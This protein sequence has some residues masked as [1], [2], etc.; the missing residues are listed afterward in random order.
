MF[1][2]FRIIIVVVC[3]MILYDHFLTE[4]DVPS[5]DVKILKNDVRVVRKGSNNSLVFAI[6]AQMYNLSP[7]I[8]EDVV[9]YFTFYDCPRVD[10]SKVDCRT[11]MT[12]DFKYGIMIKP[13][14]GGRFRHRITISRVPEAKGHLSYVVTFGGF[15]G[16]KG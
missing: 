16:D 13:N 12:R 14:T 6:D 15:K 11:I 2:I 1:G 7:Y 5:S 9:V 8:L 3:G 4:V 10:S